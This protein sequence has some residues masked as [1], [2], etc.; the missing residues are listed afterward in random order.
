MPF[1]TFAF[2][3][4][5]KSFFKPQCFIGIFQAIAPKLCVMPFNMCFNTQLLSIEMS[6]EF[7]VRNVRT[8]YAKAIKKLGLFFKYNP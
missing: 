8:I 5:P 7:V 2:G 6:S 1:L 4:S 3:L